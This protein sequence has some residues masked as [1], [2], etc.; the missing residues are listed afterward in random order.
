MQ[1][2][3]ITKHP[4]TMGQWATIKLIQLFVLALAA[5]DVLWL[6]GLA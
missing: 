2:Y 6:M 4:P 3:K 5:H 1:S